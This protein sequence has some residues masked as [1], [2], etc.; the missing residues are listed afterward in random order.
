MKICNWAGKLVYFDADLWEFINET[1]GWIVKKKHNKEEHRVTCTRGLYEGTVLA[2]ILMSCPKNMQ[3]DHING[4]SLDNRLSNL[5]I[6]TAAQNI[7]Y[8]YAA[9][10]LKK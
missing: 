1:T 6:V 4:N 10:R 9:K 3:I 2:R 8:A 5:R 7:Q